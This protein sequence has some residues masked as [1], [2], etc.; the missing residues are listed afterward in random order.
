M[1]NLRKNKIN[2]KSKKYKMSK[3]TWIILGILIVIIVSIIAVCIANK[4]SEKYQKNKDVVITE[5]QSL[6]GAK[7]YPIYIAIQST[8]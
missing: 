8:V 6:A 1:E 2:K 7:T 3:R 4:N 5:G